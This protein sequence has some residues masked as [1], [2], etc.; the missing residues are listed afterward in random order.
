MAREHQQTDIGDEVQCAKCSDFWPA[1]SE[2]FY[3]RAG[4]PH[5]WCKACY[6]NDPKTIA[7]VQRWAEKTKRVKAG[8]RV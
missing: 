2:F 1:D 5:S 8:V 6:V 7:K 3:M 4:R